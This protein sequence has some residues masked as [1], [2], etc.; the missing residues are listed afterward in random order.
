MLLVAAAPG[1]ELP[2]LLPANVPAQAGADAK[3]A[4]AAAT[5][6]ASSCAMVARCSV[7]LGAAGANEAQHRVGHVESVFGVTTAARGQGCVRNAGEQEFVNE[8]PTRLSES[9]ARSYFVGPA[10]FKIR[11]K[12]RTVLK[13]MAQACQRQ[14]ARV[15]STVTLRPA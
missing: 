11:P 7:T 2:R 1:P 15:G 12:R 4:I 14:A 10:E 5:L 13:P 3:A 9:A 8:R 6:A